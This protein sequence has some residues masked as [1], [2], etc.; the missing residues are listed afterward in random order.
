MQRRHVR[1]F[2]KLVYRE[3]A[4]AGRSFPWRNRAATPY[5][6]LVSEY[7]LQQT[8]APRAAS[9]YRVFI[10]KFPSCR[11]LARAPF[12]EV[13]R[14]WQGLGYNRRTRFLHDASKIIA[15]R[16]GGAIPRSLDE[17]VNLPGIGAYTA[18]AILAFAYNKPAICIE[19]NIRAVFIHHFFKHRKEGVRDKEILP[20]IKKTLDAKHPRLWYASLM[21]YGARLKQHI[22]NP[23]RKSAG[24]TKQSRFLGSVRQMRGLILKM[25]SARPT[26][27]AA[28][29]AS[30]DISRRANAKLAIASL[31][32]DRLLARKKSL[33]V[34][35]E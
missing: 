23:S 7:M 25:I 8:Q 20:L 31:K 30:F 10:K 4:K 18:A 19:T 17:L 3:S 6:I 26:R 12:P 16:Y 32:K 27:E 1:A 34:V 11:V 2:Q 5:H 29:L 21:D 15:Q 14:L 22:P 13:L 35:H 9:F 28:L 33:L 24:H